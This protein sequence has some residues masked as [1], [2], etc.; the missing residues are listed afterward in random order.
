MPLFQNAQEQKHLLDEHVQ[1]LRLMASVDGNAAERVGQMEAMLAD[2]E[3]QIAEVE[4]MIKGLRK[5]APIHQQRKVIPLITA[6][7]SPPAPVKK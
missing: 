6:Q 4:D 3:T 5:P 7:F 2:V 1:K